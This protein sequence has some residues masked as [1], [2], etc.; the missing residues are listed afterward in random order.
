MKKVLFF[1]IVL[2]GFFGCSKDEN[3]GLQD[4][5]NKLKERLD[6]IEKGKTVINVEFK[7]ANMIITYSSGEKVTL[8]LPK[9]LDGI[10]GTNGTNGTNGVGIQTITYDEA[11][12]ILKITLTNGNTSEF[13]IIASGN[14]LTAVL[15]S[16]VN[17]SYLLT[18]ASMGSLNIANIIYNDNNQVV[19]LVNNV[20]GDRQQVKNFE[21]TNEYSNGKLVNVNQKIGRA[22]V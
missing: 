8:P 10:N 19:S 22:H 17:G 9:G 7:D 4:D 21:V 18:S 6:A 20:I 12:A 5:V 15:L 13:K 14:L 2:T 16:D 3:A 11:T 1:L